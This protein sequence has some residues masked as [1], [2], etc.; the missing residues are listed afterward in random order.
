MLTSHLDWFAALTACKE[1]DAQFL[2]VTHPDRLARFGVGLLEHVLGL[3]DVTVVY[4]SE[5]DAL[6][7][8]AESDL[9][10]DMLAVVT[11]LSGRLYG[12][13][14]ARARRIQAATK[15]AVHDDNEESS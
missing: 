5:D 1:E 6:D 10:R 12:Q 2:L 14:S 3:L 15:M 7:A 8:S 9:V 11:S 4:V 13:R